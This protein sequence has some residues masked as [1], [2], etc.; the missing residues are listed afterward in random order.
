MRVRREGRFSSVDGVAAYLVRLN[1][2]LVAVR[3]FPGGHPQCVSR[4][5]YALDAGCAGAARGCCG[6]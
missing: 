3:N 2:R 5:D 1:L 6:Q 4:T